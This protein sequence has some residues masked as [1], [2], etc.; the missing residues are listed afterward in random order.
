VLTAAF[1][2]PSS[3]SIPAQK[4]GSVSAKLNY[5]C[6]PWVLDC[7]K[8]LCCPVTTPHLYDMD[9]HSQLSR[10][11][12][13]TV[14]GRISRLFFVDDL[15]LLASSWTGHST[16]TWSVFTSVLKISTRLRHYVYPEAQARARCKQQYSAG[17][18]DVQVGWVRR[19]LVKQTQFCLIFIALW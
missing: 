10:R 2:C 4:F 17:S 16:C 7:D 12:Y 13:H 11:G 6:L 1:Y 19:R 9:K 15:L 14:S 8:G 5:N 3:R 18:R